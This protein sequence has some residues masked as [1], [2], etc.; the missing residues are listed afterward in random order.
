MRCATLF[1]FVSS[2]RVRKDR[3][4]P[5]RSSWLK[6]VMSVAILLVLACTSRYRLDLYMTADLQYKK[7]KVEQTEFVMG[8]VISDPFAEEKLRPGSGN[9]V[10]LNLGTRG[11][12]L[13]VDKSNLLGYDEYFRCLLYLQLP[14]RPER[15][16]IALED[17]SFVQILGRYQTP[18]ENKVFL[19]DSGSLVIDSLAGKRLFGTI[20]GVYRSLLEQNL[21]FDG[22]FKV[23]IAD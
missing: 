7:V 21:Q 9:C 20:H 5:I 4:P 22:R 15:G 12:P 1:R 6:G 19:P 8:A 10:I 14:V 2:E 11:E 17:N 13:E 23:K 3:F 18:Q 16:V